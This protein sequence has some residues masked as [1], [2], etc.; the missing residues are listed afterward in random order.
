[1][2]NVLFRKATAVWL[3]ENTALTFDQIGEFCSLS[4]M[5]IHTIADGEYDITRGV[6]PLENGQLTAA[7]IKRCENDPTAKL[8]ISEYSVESSKIKKNNI[9]HNEV[10][11]A[12][13]WMIRNYGH[14]SSEEI[15]NITTAT[16]DIVETIRERGKKPIPQVTAKSPASIGLCTKEEFETY[17]IQFNSKTSAKTKKSLA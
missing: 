7:E 3:V 15:A 4:L 6:S 16:V 17:L 1:M 12:V 5:E 2:S 8:K 10:M 14:L 13:V 9:P 11:G